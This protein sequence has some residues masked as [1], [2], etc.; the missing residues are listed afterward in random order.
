MTQFN[1]DNKDVLTYGECLNPAM[2]IT[3]QDDADQYF[4][5][6]ARYIQRA[7]KKEP[8]DDDMTAEGIARINLGY[9]A[10][11]YDEETME[12][13]NRLFKTQHP[14]FGKTVP[15]ATEA[16]QAGMNRAK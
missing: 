2:K 13:V 11:Y 3:D 8:R 14:I 5:N 4:T 9:Y 16:L 6:Y 15:T 12:R 1:P 10:G 7:L